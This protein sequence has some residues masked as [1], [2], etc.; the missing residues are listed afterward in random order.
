MT[1]KEIENAVANLPHGELV[2]FGVWFEEHQSRIW[3]DQIEQDS[4]AGR[5]DSLISQAKAE[6]DAGRSRPL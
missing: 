6:S 5:F 1:V 3:D 4:Q 2:E